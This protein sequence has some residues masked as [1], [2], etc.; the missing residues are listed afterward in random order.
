MTNGGDTYNIGGQG[1][2]IHIGPGGVIGRGQVNAENIAAGDIVIHAAAGS[3]KHSFVDLLA[4][5]KGMIITASEKGELPEAVATEVIG[6]LD[7]A[8]EMLATG[9]APAREGLLG[10]LENVV[11]TIENVVDLVE[12]KGGILVKA[13]PFA[14]MLLRVAGDLF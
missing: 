11:E 2:T 4:E 6:E 1:S 10:K 5:L 12:E 8:E 7:S 13:L 3:G 9:K 14:I